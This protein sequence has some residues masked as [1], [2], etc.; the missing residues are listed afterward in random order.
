MIADYHMHLAGDGEPYTDDQFSIEWI[1]SYT[2]RAAE[3]GI[4]EI[5]LTDHV[6]RF[7]VART[8][9]DAPLWQAQAVGDL[10]RYVSVVRAAQDAGLAVKLGLEVDW[11]P[12]REREIAALAGAHPWDFLIGSYHWIGEREIDHEANSV[13]D[14]TP[15]AE[16]WRRYTDGFCAA[17]QS[18]LFDCMAHPD[19]P[20]VFGHRLRPEPLAL[21]REMADAAQAGDVCIEVST[22][23]LR[24]PAAEIYPAPKLLGMF[25]ARRVPVTLGSDA[26]AP[27]GVGKDFDR[28]LGALAEAGYRELTFF[29]R[30]ERT[31][32]LV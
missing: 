5:G 3:L 1:G 22:A 4:A 14:T 16:V 25:A 17:A 2:D 19:V 24:T 26:H 13:W 23:G 31:A 12:G 18:G 28:A 29:S 20:K 11:V 8:W 21:Y 27:A 9:I 7:A 30:R 10:T 32:Q 6:Y 15:V